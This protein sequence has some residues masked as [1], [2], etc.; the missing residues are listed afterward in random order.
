MRWQKVACW[1]FAIFRKMTN[2]ARS[3]QRLD[4]NFKKVDKRDDKKGILTKCD[5]NR[6]GKFTKVSNTF[7][8]SPPKWLTWPLDV[9][10]GLGFGWFYWFSLYWKNFFSNLSGIRNSPTYNGERYFFGIVRHER[11]FCQCRILF[12]QEFIYKL[13]SS[14]NQSSGHITPSNV[15]WSAPK[16]DS[17]NIWSVDRCW[18]VN[19]F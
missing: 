15:K 7:L 2:L 13:F 11:Y 1:Q 14:R 5:Y 4:K 3:Y 19:H 10:G 6:N 12:S 8:P 9:C 16:T 18:L 17:Q